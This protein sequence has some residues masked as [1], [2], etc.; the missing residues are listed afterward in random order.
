MQ[1]DQSLAVLTRADSSFGIKFLN[2]LA[3]QGVKPKL[4]CVEYTPFSKKLISDVQPF[5]FRPLIYI[6]H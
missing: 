4:L 1:V 2:K 6:D 3:L 5:I